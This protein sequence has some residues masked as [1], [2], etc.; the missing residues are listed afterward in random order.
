MESNASFTI[1]ILILILTAINPIITALSHILQRVSHSECCGSI[2]T[3]RSSN[4]NRR[5]IRE[6]KK[7]DKLNI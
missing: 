5:N 7:D 4:I 6:L 1:Q 3:L 2:V